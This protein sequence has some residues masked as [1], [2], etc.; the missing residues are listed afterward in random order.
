[1]LSILICLFWKEIVQKRWKNRVMNIYIPPHL[2]SSTVNILLHLHMYTLSSPY[3]H[4]PFSIWIHTSPYVYTLLHMCTLFSIWVHSLLYMS[5]HPSPYEHTLFSIWVHT[6]L[7]MSTLFSLWVHTLLHMYTHSF[8]LSKHLKVG[9]RHLPTLPLNVSLHLQRTE[10]FSFTS[11]MPQLDLRKST[12]THITWLITSTNIQSE[13][14]FPQLAT[15]TFTSS[16]PPCT[17]LPLHWKVDATSLG[18]FP[19]PQKKL[20][21]HSHLFYLDFLDLWFMIYDWVG[22]GKNSES[23]PGSA[24]TSQVASRCPPWI[25]ETCCCQ[26]LF[27]SSRYSKRIFFL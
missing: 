7:H 13:I 4:T 3:V 12:L 18:L 17:V 20:P 24:T 22:K 15:M 2:Y 19:P 25:E 9:F 26:G 8:L 21:I 27:Q 10:T 6:L 23:I 1:M 16:P 14:R 5:T 11:I